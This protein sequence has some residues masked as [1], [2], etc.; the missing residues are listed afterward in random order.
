MMTVHA[1]WTVGA[2]SLVGALLGG[3][4]HPVAQ[5]LGEVKLRSNRTVAAALST[6]ILFGLL[7]WRTGFHTELLAFS[8]V[9]LTSVPLMAIDFAELRLP[10]RLI[11]PTCLVTLAI[12]TVAAAGNHDGQALLRAVTGMLALPTAYLVLALATRGGFGSGD[13][14]LA[15]VVGLVLAWRSWP[16]LA[17]GT[18]LALAL[19]CVTGLVKIALGRA[20]R[21]APIPYGPAMITGAFTVLVAP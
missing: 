2:W 21:S 13:V 7:A 4:F 8:C 11:W 15:A 20:S 12:L 18:M 10:T 14:R 1:I 9:A 3:A 16:A 19:A 6:S 5:R 17:T